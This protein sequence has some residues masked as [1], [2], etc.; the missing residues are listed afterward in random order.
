MTTRTYGSPEAFK[1]ALEQRLR[2]SAETGVGFARGRQLLVFERFLA[3]VAAVLGNA[4]TLKGGVVLE[5]RLERARTTR[6]IDLRM[7]GSPK[8]I[9]Q[10]LQK[11]ARH[12]LGDFMTFELGLDA[13]HP[14]IQNDGMQYD[15]LRF[16]A[17]CRLAGKLYGQPFG[18]DVVFGDPIIGEPDV[19]QADDVLAFAGIAP[20]TLRLYPVET[21]IAEKVHAYTMPRARPNTRVK[22]LPDIALL[23][24]TRPIDA[25]R[26][27]EAL[28]QTFTF[29]K[30]HVL[31]AELPEPSHAWTAPYTAMAREDELAWPTLDAVAK[32]AQAFMDP[33]LEGALDATWDPVAWTWRR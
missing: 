22:D 9:L 16:R 31:P 30:T 32:A 11:V 12:D 20:P 33:V 4:A 18:V 13:D 28:D 25:R 7:V 27:R 2:A 26:L 29:R 19:V 1:Q 21:H 17:E 8:D 14:E 6:D 3:R 24:T 5:L 23:A 10:T 15:G